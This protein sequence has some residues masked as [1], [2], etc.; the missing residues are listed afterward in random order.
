M[1]RTF[2]YRIYATKEQESQLFDILN[3]AKYIYNWARGIRKDAYE[4]LG[5]SVS[6]NEQGKML[7]QTRGI[8]ADWRAYPQDIQNHVLRR[9]D[10]AFKNFFSSVKKGEKRK[11]PRYRTRNRSITFSLRGNKQS[12]P[13]RKTGKRHDT[14]VVPKVGKVKIRISRE[15]QGKAKEITIVKKASGWYAH[16]SCEVNEVLKKSPENATGI[17][18]G[19][20]HYLTDIDGR[21]VS[22]PRYYRKSQ[23]LLAKK[24]RVLSR[25]KKGSRRFKKL[26]YEIA[27]LHERITNRRSDFLCKTVNALF[28]KYD[29]IIVEKLQIQNMVRNSKLSKSISDA[30]WGYFLSW[31]ASIAERDGLHFY[32]IDPHNTSQVCSKCKTKSEDKMT[33]DK[34]TFTCKHCN[35][36]IDRDH[37][38]ALNIVTKAADAFRGETTLVDLM[39]REIQAR[40]DDLNNHKPLGLCI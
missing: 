11:Y 9:V 5:Y 16:I 30:S 3:H 18:V 12:E 6:Y 4:Q 36:K 28:R 29:V 32:Q 7:T 38:S 10:K 17:D 24:Q 39:K 35:L 1:R 13:I 14:I 33:L 31:C 20:N 26:C 15:L 19:L 40:L 22:N 37:N 8:R 25:K 34:R 21:T 2:R 27:L 23:A